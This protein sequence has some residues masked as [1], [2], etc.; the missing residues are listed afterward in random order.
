MVVG[1]RLSSTY[2]TENKRPFH[3]SGNVLVKFLVN[4]FFNGRI[5]DIMTGYR[6]FSPAF[7][8]S[9]PVLS[10]GF[11]IETEM[12]IHALDKNFHIQSIPV[13]YRDRPDGSISKLNTFSDGFKVLRTIFLL[14]KD[15]KPLNFFSTISSIVMALSIALLIPVFIDFFNSGLVLR[16]PTLIGAGFMLLTAILLF[17]CGLILDTQ[18]KNYRKSFEVELNT[19]S[20]IIRAKK[21]QKP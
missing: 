20:M 16:F 8:K 18:V 3:N 9:F 4:K 17:C 15:Y 21:Q 5:S 14:Y 13:E 11:E 12:T 7:V 2:F 19:L 10:H 1:D 6:A